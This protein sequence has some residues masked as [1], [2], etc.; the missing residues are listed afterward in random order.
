MRQMVFDGASD[1]RE[2]IC[3][4]KENDT[5]YFSWSCDDTRSENYHIN[6]GTAPS[7]LSPIQVKGTIL[8]KNPQKG[9]YATGHHTVLKDWEDVYHILY[10]RFTTDASVEAIGEERGYNRE[11]CIDALHFDAAGNILPIVPTDRKS[12]V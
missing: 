9:I 2:A 4:F 6:Y 12:V 1:F 11:I 3:V 8:E 7:L 10:H 5:Y